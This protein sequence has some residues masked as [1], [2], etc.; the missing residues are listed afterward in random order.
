[1]P[2]QKQPAGQPPS[3]RSEKGIQRQIAD[4]EARLAAS[5]TRFR[6]DLQDLAREVELD[7]DA[8]LPARDALILPLDA[9]RKETAERLAEH[10]RVAEDLRQDAARQDKAAGVAQQAA[11]SARALI[12]R[13]RRTGE[14]ALE[15]L[16]A[17]TGTIPQPFRPGLDLPVDVADLHE[18]D[19]GPVGEQTESAQERARVLEARQREQDRLRRE[20]DGVRE[21]RSA[22]TTRR[23][24]EV[25]A[26]ITA[27]VADL[28]AHRDVLV[29]SVSRLGLDTNV[30]AAVSARD[31]AAL[32]SH[33]GALGKRAAEDSP[34]RRRAFAGRFRQGGRRPRGARR[35][36][37][38]SGR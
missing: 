27:L 13:T 8:P 36:R 10:D 22:L 37:R 35:H 29:E 6:N 28:H 31:A 2:R 30:P 23:V 17:A 5:E 18:V 15:R 16:G 19:M 4:T 25:D 11:S 34:R 26:P 21:A 33:I 38:T 3:T 32:E 7:P 20:I 1:M 14:E 9:M 24:D 12:D